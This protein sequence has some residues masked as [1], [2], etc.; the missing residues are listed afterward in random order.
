MSQVSFP[1][2]TCIFVTIHLPI[3]LNFLHMGMYMCMN[4]YMHSWMHIN[5]FASV[6]MHVYKCVCICILLVF[7]HVHGCICIIINT[8]INACIQMFFHLLCIIT[9]LLL[10]SFEHGRASPGE[11]RKKCAQI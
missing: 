7:M 2:I 9:H 6:Y 3:F 10:Y 4:I 8:C 5:V 11:S 1:G